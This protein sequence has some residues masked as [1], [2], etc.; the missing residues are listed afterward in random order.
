[1]KHIVKFGSTGTNASETVE[2]TVG[3]AITQDYS[4]Y[5]KM[6]VIVALTI[7]GTSPT[8]T[9]VIE[10]LFGG[11]WVETARSKALTATG[12]YTLCQGIVPPDQTSVK[13]NG[14]FWPL[15]SGAAKQIKTVV[16]GTQV[17]MS[18][19]IYFA[20]YKD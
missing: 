4:E 10:E 9:I 8:C 13:H 18:A 3:S 20:F 19:D 15:G 7:T 12:N 1:M 17:V 14:A 2:A 5:S 6:D 16:T 11:E